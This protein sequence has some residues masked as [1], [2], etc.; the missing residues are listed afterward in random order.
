MKLNTQ[1]SMFQ[2]RENWGQASP[3][4]TQ[5]LLQC[6][7][8]DEDVKNGTKDSCSYSQY[9][10]DYRAIEKCDVNLQYVQK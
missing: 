10:F 2:Y 7:S 5:P 8:I 1:P 4:P 3:T 9:H 6:I